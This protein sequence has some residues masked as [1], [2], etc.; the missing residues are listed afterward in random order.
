VRIYLAARYRRQHELRGY[1][2]ELEVLGYQVTSRWIRGS[3]SVSGGLE[4]P[5]WA[6]IALEDVEDVAAADMIVCFLEP[7]GGG[8]GGRHAEFGM[9][10]GS[11]KRTI[12]VGEPEHLFHTLPSVEVY[13]KWP[14]AL[15]ALR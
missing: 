3:H 12:V 5:R 6:E 8:S 9:A 2:D 13:R 7:D 4:D 15:A 14:D 11:G 1:A 10:L